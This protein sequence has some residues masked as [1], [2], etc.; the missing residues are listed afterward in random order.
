MSRLYVL[1][2]FLLSLISSCTGMYDNI[3]EYW[4]RGEIP[5]I[6]R[7]DSAVTYAGK[8]QIKLE[9]QVGSDPRIDSCVI[10]WNFKKDSIVIYVDPQKINEG[11]YS[12]LLKDMPEGSYVFDLKHIGELGYPSLTYEVLGNVYGENYQSGLLPRKILGTDWNNG[13]LILRLGNDDSKYVRFTYTKSNG[14]LNTVVSLSSETECLLP[15][16]KEGSSICYE[17]IY[18]PEENA[19]DEF[20]VDAEYTLP[21]M[22]DRNGWKA[23]ALTK[24]GTPDEHPDYPASNILDGNSETFYHNHW[25]PNTGVPHTI[26]VDM[27][28]IREVVEFSLSIEEYTKKIEVR[29][30]PDNVDWKFVGIM[31]F[32]EYNSTVTLRLDEALPARYIRLTGIEGE[33]DNTPIREFYVYGF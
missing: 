16:C 32:K 10:Y 12:V 29:V 31:E 4:K 25:D 17:T 20:K 8:N 26:D 24:N 11:K 18:L 15:D 22:F 28:D 19:L 33:G 1:M 7:P 13:D 2:V 21:M 23:E 5:Y 27:K 9:W 6:G 3:E 30:S 14:E